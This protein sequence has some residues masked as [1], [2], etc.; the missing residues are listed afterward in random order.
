MEKTDDEFGH[1]IRAK[2]SVITTVLSTQTKVDETRL[3]RHT[4]DKLPA[5]MAMVAMVADRL[6]PAPMRVIDAVE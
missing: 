3:R 4:N 1:L 5:L 2:T 6:P